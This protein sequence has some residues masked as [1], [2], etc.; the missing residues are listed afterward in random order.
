MI[1]FMAIEEVVGEL[2]SVLP[3][4]AVDKISGLVLILKALS[5]A[6]IFYFIYIV[7]MGILTYR[8]MKKLEL[9]NEK[10]DIIDKK[11]NKLLKKK[12]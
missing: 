6:A 8:R 1:S 12:S 10:V 3:I 11:L 2:A 7:V 4:E 9:L 5:F